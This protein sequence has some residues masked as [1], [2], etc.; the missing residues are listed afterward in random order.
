MR[1]NARD[2]EN[3]FNP[4]HLD[5]DEIRA[6]IVQQLTE[7]PDL[8]PDLVAISVEGGFVTLTGRVGT[9]Q[10]LQAIQHTVT[11]VLG[12]HTLSNEIVIDELARGE[13][14]EA[15]DDAAAQEREADPLLGDEGLGTDPQA[16]HLMDDTEGDLYGTRNV[17]D[18]VEKGQ[19]YNPPDRPLQEG[20]WSEEQ[21]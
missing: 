21:H 19:S 3:V 10:E 8:D 14:P 11:D 6:L 18:A 7:N 1:G 5:D 2:Y 15:A 13:A 20:S 12:I 17:G 4:D 16:D 9:E